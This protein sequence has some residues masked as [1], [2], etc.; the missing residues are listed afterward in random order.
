M[1]TQ[2]LAA[3]TPATEP[4]QPAKATRQQERQLLHA[5][6]RV[7]AERFSAQDLHTVRAAYG[8][9]RY[10]AAL[11]RAVEQY[12]LYDMRAEINKAREDEQA[13][14]AAAERQRRLIETAEQHRR[15]SLE[16][17]VAALRGRL[18]SPDPAEHQRVVIEKIRDREAAWLVDLQALFSARVGEALP[19]WLL[20]QRRD[21]PGYREALW[22]LRAANADGSGREPGLPASAQPLAYDERALKELVL[23]TLRG[24]NQDRE[25]DQQRG[26]K[27]LLGIA[28]AVLPQFAAAFARWQHRPLEDYLIDDVVRSS[29][30]VQAIALV[31]EGVADVAAV[32]VA[33]AAEIIPEG[34][35]DA[36]LRTIDT[37]KAT[38]PSQ[39]SALESRY[40]LTF[41]QV[42]HRARQHQPDT[43]RAH[44]K[45]LAG[46]FDIAAYH[47]TLALLHHEP[48]PAEELYFLLARSSSA[49]RQA[50]IKL[51]KK[52]ARDNVSFCQLESD[53]NR[54]VRQAQPGNPEAFTTLPLMAHVRS[55][56]TSVVDEFLGFGS[57]ELHLVTGLLESL[58]RVTADPVAVQL[59]QKGQ[60]PQE[61][62]DAAKAAAADA[63]GAAFQRRLYREIATE[64]EQRRQEDVR[65]AAARVALDAASNS[66]EPSIHEALKDSNAILRGRIERQNAHI[67]AWQLEPGL[68][69]AQRAELVGKARAALAHDEAFAAQQRAGLITR[70]DNERKLYFNPDGLQ[71]SNAEL[72]LARL[73]L[74]A[75]A[76]PADEIYALAASREFERMTERVTAIWASGGIEALITDARQPRADAAGRELRP[77]FSFANLPAL[78]AASPFGRNDL[79][80]VQR[81]KD[82]VAGAL[83]RRSW[84]GGGAS[85][86][87][88]ALLLTASGKTDA[89][90]GA[91]RLDWEINQGVELLGSHAASDLGEVVKFLSAPGLGTQRRE[92]VIAA[93][94]SQYGAGYLTAQAGET[95]VRLFLRRI[96]FWFE[97]NSTHYLKL[98]ELLMPA[99]TRSDKARYARELDEASAPQSGKAAVRGFSDWWES[100][101]GT[102]R[103]AASARS[104]D[105][106]EYIAQTSPAELA[107][108]QRE[109][110]RSSADDLASYYYEEFKSRRA[111]LKA[112]EDQVVERI[113]DVVELAVDSGITLFTGGAAL[114][115]IIAAVVAA[116][117]NMAVHE[118]L[119]G[120]EYKLASAANLN[121]LVQAAIGAIAVEGD[122]R[123][124]LV[125]K[126]LPLKGLEKA[127][128][129]RGRYA[130]EWLQNT[131]TGGIEGLLSAGTDMAINTALQ[132][133]WISAEDIRRNSYLVLG[134]LAGKAISTPGTVNF[135][136]G[137]VLTYQN[138]WEQFKNVLFFKAALK[139]ENIAKEYVK[140]LLSAHAD[141]PFVD[142]LLDIT[143]KI[144]WGEARVAV[145][146]SVSYLTGRYNTGAELA[147]VALFR[148]RKPQEFAEALAKGLLARYGKADAP[149][150]RQRCDA[151]IAKNPSLSLFDAFV[152]EMQGDPELLSKLH[153]TV[154]EAA[155]L[156]LGSKPARGILAS[157]EG[158]T[159]LD[160]LLGDADVQRRLVSAGQQRQLNQARDD[161]LATVAQVNEA[162]ARLPAPHQNLEPAAVAAEHTEQAHKALTA[163]A[164][165]TAQAHDSVR[166]PPLSEAR[167]AFAATRPAAPSTRP[168]VQTRSSV[169][170][171]A[172]RDASAA[173]PL[174]GSRVL[175]TDVPLAGFHS[176]TTMAAI[177]E[178]GKPRTVT[179]PDGS[180]LTV[181]HNVYPRLN[182]LSIA[183][184]TRPGREVSL[185]EARAFR[186]AYRD[187]HL[188][189][190]SGRTP[191]VSATGRFHLMNYTVRL[192]EREERK[193]GPSPRDIQ[194]DQL[195]RRLG[196]GRHAG[197]VPVPPQGEARSRGKDLAPAGPRIA[198]RHPPLPAGYR[199]LA[200][201]SRKLG[202][203]F[204]LTGPA[205]TAVTPSEL[206][207]LSHQRALLFDWRDFL[208]SAA[209]RAPGDA[210]AQRQAAAMDHVCA[211]LDSPPETED[212]R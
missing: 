151:R 120:T 82:K 67:K 62:P 27:T 167:R 117:A 12:R 76:S 59:A 111:E 137:N 130:Q 77:S 149:E 210:W 54:Y 68:S 17:A 163:T 112:L 211:M 119:L 23:M 8:N 44:L 89:E 143:L 31:R 95:P 65:L 52:F 13:R 121:A 4:R 96:H 10:S 1:A 42:G 18:L 26:Y 146:G 209:Q 160:Q 158:A 64:R 114:P 22:R 32:H 173:E 204:D 144:A 83:S 60:E 43:L 75:D 189:H 125:V 164:T 194:L 176:K 175:D 40:N 24:F 181:P 69:E 122:L 182:R 156:A 71:L 159:P 11:R 177:I 198:E 145:R 124:R 150:L 195:H 152:L 48:T 50:A 47:H 139:S 168:T 157:S 128:G 116:G 196:V 66:D 183:D 9:G 127:A 90:R 202:G 123:G 21:T 153:K 161:V 56:L 30:S 126:R 78:L 34:G 141:Q 200:D 49:Q 171:T 212:A 190:L 169:A 205:K 45:A 33:V 113:S 74:M 140:L 28:P 115:A 193:N 134:K 155:N 29:I 206:Q 25:A 201:F 170:T 58:S 98:R 118:A 36:R 203:L 208:R 14:Q 7:N 191:H 165:A 109:S 105:W 41:R 104:Q 46:R 102:H 6:L 129:G 88:R 73:A 197:A 187:H 180:K 94:V 3:K 136:P 99:S 87:Q 86:W 20:H 37:L 132:D 38:R 2:T 91:D 16:E 154:L 97:G 188:G 51:L 93:Y 57:S 172:R 84:L 72:P 135:H 92:A 199:N 192:L 55:V 15:Q 19:V 138:P 185:L 178:W 179:Q 207:H 5:V 174:K 100:K 103:R 79:N 131:I 110:G 186:D 63:G 166:E 148:K 61:P 142:A 162:G 39:R 70:I 81:Q 107:R 80:V 147:Q 85:L 184:L 101:W 133:R 108:L 106:L 53:W 35:E